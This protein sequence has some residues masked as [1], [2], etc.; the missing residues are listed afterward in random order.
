MGKKTKPQK[1]KER[2][3]FAAAIRDPKGPFKPKVVPNAKY[4]PIPRRR[5]HKGKL[6]DD[7]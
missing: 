3:F 6:E 4:V 1:P 2:N 5:K 7:Q